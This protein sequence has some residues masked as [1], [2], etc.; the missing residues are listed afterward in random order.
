MVFGCASRQ[1]RL[2]ECVHGHESRRNGWAA[3]LP[4]EPMA[5]HVE[6]ARPATASGAEPSRMLP[7]RPPD[8]RPMPCPWPMACHGAAALSSTGVGRTAVAWLLS[9]RPRTASLR[10]ASRS[11]PCARGIANSP[12]RVLRATR[13]V[14]RGGMVVTLWLPAWVGMAISPA[15]LRGLSSLCVS[16]DCEGP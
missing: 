16:W 2:M 3:A 13:S 12:S 8:S 9:L 14:G 11:E 7:S 15:F 6:P 4:S 10:P 5:A 1:C